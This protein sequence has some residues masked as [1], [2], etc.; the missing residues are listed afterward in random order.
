MK[1]DNSI[2]LKSCSIDKVKG[3]IIIYSVFKKC[4]NKVIK[5]IGRK[6]YKL[7]IKK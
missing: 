3:T 6:L 1:D 2:T 5:L 4:K 7:G